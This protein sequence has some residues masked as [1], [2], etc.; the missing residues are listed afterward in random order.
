ME[1]VATLIR[2]AISG[3]TPLCPFTNSDNVFRVTPRRLPIAVGTPCRV[4]QRLRRLGL[5]IL[6]FVPVQHREIVPSLGNIGTI[7]TQGLLM[8]RVAETFHP[9]ISHALAHSNV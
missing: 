2:I 7:Q 3:L 5:R 4:V 6:A 9:A 8:A 1:V